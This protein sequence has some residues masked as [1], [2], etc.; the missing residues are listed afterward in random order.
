MRRPKLLIWAEA[1]RF[2]NYKIGAERRMAMFDMLSAEARDK[3]NYQTRQANLSWIRK[4]LQA[5]RRWPL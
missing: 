4:A 1:D 5:E 2:R 3:I